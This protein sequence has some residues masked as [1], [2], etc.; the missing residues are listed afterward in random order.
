MS[1]R[2]IK[3]IC[4]HFLKNLSGFVLRY[5]NLCKLYGYIRQ[6]SVIYSRPYLCKVSMLSSLISNGAVHLV[7]KKGQVVPKIL[8]KDR[9]I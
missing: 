4:L 7:L 1:T 9:Q 2:K 3:L 5:R 6:V 8:T